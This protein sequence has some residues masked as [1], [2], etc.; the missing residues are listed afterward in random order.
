MPGSRIPVYNSDM[1]TKFK[2]DYII[3]FPWNLKQEI[4]SQLE[5]TKEWGAK[6]IIAIPELTVL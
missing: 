4:M 1:I 2:P 3:I 5:Y 6:F